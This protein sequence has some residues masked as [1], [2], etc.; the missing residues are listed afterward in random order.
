MPQH[1]LLEQLPLAILWIL[2][3]AIHSLL[4]S[5]AVK[6]GLG[7]AW[8]GLMPVYRLLFNGIATVLLLPLLYLLLRHPGPPLWAWTGVAWWFAQAAAALALGGFLLTLKGYDGLEFVGLRQWRRR[9]RGIED[10]ESFRLSP[11]HRFVRH[12][13]YFLGLVILWTRDMNAAWLVSSILASL[14][15]VLGARLEER[16]LRVFHGDVYRAYQ[17]RVPALIPLPW[18]R[19]STSEAQRLVEMAR[20]GA[21]NG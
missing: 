12:P 3:F 6:R 18:R 11:L 20:P 8:P 19:L 16:K 14:Y 13:W 21:E 9:E 4:A 1:W 15:C 7:R 2:Y 17:Q 5:L 10:R